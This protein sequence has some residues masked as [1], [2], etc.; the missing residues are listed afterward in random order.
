MQSATL[1]SFIESFHFNNSS[2]LVSNVSR[3]K[4]VLLK[5]RRNLTRLAELVLNT[6]SDNGN[7]TALANSFRNGRTKSADDVVLFSG[8]DGTCLLRRLQDDL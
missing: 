1:E 6:H 4:T 8:N 2:C 5:Q 3:G 7:G